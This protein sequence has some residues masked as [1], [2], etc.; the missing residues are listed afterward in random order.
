VTGLWTS[1]E[2]GKP[3]IRST[4]GFAYALAS[5]NPHH[6]PFMS[7]HELGDTVKIG[8][9]DVALFIQEHGAGMTLG[10]RFGQFAYSTDAMGMPE[11]AFSVLSGIDLWVVGA[12]HSVPNRSIRPM[13]T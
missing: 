12:A 9:I 1:T 7:T 6:W 3:W 5:E 2:T 4:P 8:D 11:A 13:P 10:F